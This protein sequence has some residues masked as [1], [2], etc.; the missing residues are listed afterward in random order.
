MLLP[1][2]PGNSEMKNCYSNFGKSKADHVVALE[3]NRT[4]DMFCLR[5]GVLFYKQ[6]RLARSVECPPEGQRGPMRVPG[7]A[8]A[9]QALLKEDLPKGQK[10]LTRTWPKE[11]W[12]KE[13]IAKL[14]FFGFYPRPITTSTT[15][16]EVSDCE[17]WRLWKKHQNEFSFFVPGC[18]TVV[19]L[20]FFAVPFQLTWFSK[21][22][23]WTMFVCL[24]I[25]TTVVISWSIFRPNQLCFFFCPQ[26]DTQIRWF[27]PHWLSF[28]LSVTCANV[29]CK[30]AC[31]VIDDEL[32]VSHRTH[33]PFRDRN[34]VFVNPF[35]VIRD[36]SWN[37]SWTVPGFIEGV[38]QDVTHIIW[39]RATT[40]TWQVTP[41][42]TY[43]RCMWHFAWHPHPQSAT[44]WFLRP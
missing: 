17:V 30:S 31:V 32:E 36:K 22:M 12:R 8:V 34:L 39:E 20:Q 26:S 23:C 38:L 25:S 27:W 37:V 42:W 16:R 35:G 3:Q 14:P 11:D 5:F 4:W 43:A 29:F 10:A 2:G 18:A 9:R 41:V 33:G 7:A 19:L 24:L 6:N 15:H 21:A 13:G 40:H 44:V 1:G 28:L